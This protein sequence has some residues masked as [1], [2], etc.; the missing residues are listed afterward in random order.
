MSDNEEERRVKARHDVA[1]FYQRHPSKRTVSRREL[2]R[3]DTTIETQSP[4][5]EEASS[6][7][8]DVEDETYLPSPRAPHHGKGNGL[9]SASGSG[10][11]RDEEIEEENDGDD[12]EEEETF[13]MEEIIPTSYVHMW[14]PVFR[15][16]LNP[17][18][19]EWVSYK[20]KIDLVREKMK[21]N[22]RLV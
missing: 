8:D 12:Q 7:E 4:A 21:E 9:A 3:A 15:Q 18:W 2:P 1:Q 16:P 20:G 13:A 6:A 22:L 17:D 14:N 11:A 5:R 10:A 19:R